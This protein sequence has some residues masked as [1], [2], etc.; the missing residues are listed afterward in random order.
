M[1]LSKSG[2]TTRDI[3]VIHPA[4]GQPI[5]LTVTMVSTYSPQ[6]REGKKRVAEMRREKAKKA[7]EAGFLY[8]P[9]PEDD[10]AE[11]IAL[12]ASCLTGWKWSKELNWKG[13]ESPAFTPEKVVEVLSG[14]DWLPDKLDTEL[15]KERLFFQD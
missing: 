5:G 4:T 6:F 1:D 13:E 2:T 11:N 9:S 12:I 3:E 8:Q 14:V 7:F 10:R 15:G